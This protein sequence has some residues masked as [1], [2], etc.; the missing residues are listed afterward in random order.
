MSHYDIKQTLNQL[1]N[2]LD[3]Q[4][5]IEPADL[6]T[7]PLTFKAKQGVFEFNNCF[8]LQMDGFYYSTEKSNHGHDVLT[9]IHSIYNKMI[10][11]Q[12]VPKEEILKNILLKKIPEA[13]IPA[14]TGSIQI[15]QAQNHIIALFTLKEQDNI[16]VMADQ[17]VALFPEEVG[18]QLVVLDPISFAL[19][20]EGNNEELVAETGEMAEA[21]CETVEN[22]EGI[23][24]VS[25]IST[26]CTDVKR[27]PY[28]LD[29]AKATIQIARK[30]HLDGSVWLYDEILMERILADLPAERS[31]EYKK[32]IFTEQADKWLN[33]EMINTIHTFFRCDLNVSDTARQMFIHRNTLM[34][35]LDKIQKMTGLDLRKFRDA[36]IFQIL[37]EIPY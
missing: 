16:K 36:V 32:I 15:D 28:S 6:L 19:I 17:L 37:I 18:E 33:E 23:S 5:N 9:L 1:L 22:E 31:T 25:G 4:V 7:I 20:R 30:F 27:L 29:Q 21:F 12:S 26:V 34:Y 3:I 35:R 8:Y 14:Y 10:E 13:D 24:L 2:S 11:S